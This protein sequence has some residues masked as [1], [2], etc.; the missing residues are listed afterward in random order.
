LEIFDYRGPEAVVAEQDI[1]AAKNQ[2]GFIEEVVHH[3]RGFPVQSQ[4]EA[5]SSCR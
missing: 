2:D 5:E 1:A 3:N 4:P